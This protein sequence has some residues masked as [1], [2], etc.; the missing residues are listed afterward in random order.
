MTEEKNQKV[1][2]ETSI[3]EKSR[4]TYFW[5]FIIS[6]FVLHV[7]YHDYKAHMYILNES[8]YDHADLPILRHNKKFYTLLRTEINM[9]DFIKFVEVDVH[10]QKRDDKVE[11]PVDIE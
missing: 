5:T 2:R 7:F 3:L 1:K 10:D 6:I 4:I 9:T 11:D 8:D